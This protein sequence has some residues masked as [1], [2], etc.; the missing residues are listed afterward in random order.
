M[1]KL[2][3]GI[4]PEVDS[5]AS[6]H[7]ELQHKA[8]R[9]ANVQVMDLRVVFGNPVLLRARDNVGLALSSSSPR[10]RDAWRTTNALPCKNPNL[11]F[12]RNDQ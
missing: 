6:D 11:N 9:I 5:F 10:R 4:A 12:R 7:A 1:S 3:A 2:K 8:D